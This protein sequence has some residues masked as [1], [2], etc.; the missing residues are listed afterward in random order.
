MLKSLELKNLLNE[1]HAKIKTMKV[2]SNAVA[3]NDKIA[4]IN[5][6]D[7]GIR[8][9]CSLILDAFEGHVNTDEK[10]SNYMMLYAS[11]A[12]IASELDLSREYVCHCIN[13]MAETVLCPFTKIRQGLNQCNIYVMVGKKNLV[14]LLKQIYAAQQEEK[15][16]KSKE[17]QVKEKKQWFKK[18]EKGTFNDYPQREYDFDELEKNLLGWDVAEE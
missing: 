2:F 15:N 9:V 3:I 14:E 4:F 10:N 16:E 18:K 12:T 7:K 5:S 6:L 11:Q 13:R 8:G 1:N 17:S